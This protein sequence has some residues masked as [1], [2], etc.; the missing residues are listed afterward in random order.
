MNP[1]AAVTFAKQAE[2]NTTTFLGFV[3]IEDGYRGTMRDIALVSDE[4]EPGAILAVL[5]FGFYHS[6]F[7]TPC[8]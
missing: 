4:A 5:P 6:T 7:G 1:F 8:R 3:H 2:T